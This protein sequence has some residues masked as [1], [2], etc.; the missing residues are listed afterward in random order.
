MG[1]GG[2][3]GGN[4]AE[5]T[6]IDLNKINRKSDIYTQNHNNNL[7]TIFFRTQSWI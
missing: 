1:R 2:E 4:W 7:C 3:R 6:E 5:T